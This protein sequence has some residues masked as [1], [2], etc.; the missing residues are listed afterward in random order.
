M[1]D[2][3]IREVMSRYAQTISLTLI[4]SWLK[5]MRFFVHSATESLAQT[6]L[7]LFKMLR[8]PGVPLLVISVLLF[9]LLPLLVLVLVPVMESVSFGARL[10]VEVV[11]TSVSLMAESLENEVKVDSTLYLL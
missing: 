5:L 7:R 4:N 3:V 10:S 9:K 11:F 8:K 2:N 6:R 1:I